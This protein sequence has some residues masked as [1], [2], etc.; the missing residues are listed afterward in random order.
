MVARCTDSEVY[1]SSW[2]PAPGYRVEDVARG[3]GTKATVW[4]EGPYEVTL[5]AV[6]VAGVPVA[7]VNQ[8]VNDGSG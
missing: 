5:N 2:S 3:P 6:C 8:E 7:Q 1:L 4:F